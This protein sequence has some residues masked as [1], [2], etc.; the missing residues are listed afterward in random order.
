[1]NIALKYSFVVI[2]TVSFFGCSTV[3]ERPTSQLSVTEPAQV[4]AS[5]ETALR[6]LN[7]ASQSGAI[8]LFPA[9][10]ILRRYYLLPTSAETLISMGTNAV[11]TLMEFKD[12]GDLTRSQLASIC[13]GIIE[14]EHVEKAAPR[15]DSK[16]GISIVSYVVLP[17]R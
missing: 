6:D 12:S 15:K 11:P 17:S 1:M 3:R 7:V 2:V 16:S 9:F 14:A 5:F 4:A 10:T 8:S 13:I